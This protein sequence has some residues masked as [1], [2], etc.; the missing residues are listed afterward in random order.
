M[1]DIGYSELLLIAVVA[2]IVIGPKDL[3]RVMRTVGQWVGRARGMARHFRSGIDT[4][5]REAELEE[6]EKKWREENERILRDH[7][8]ANPLADPLALEA[9]AEVPADSAEAP[10]TAG[11]EPPVETPPGPSSESVDPS[12]GFAGPPHSDPD[13]VAHGEELG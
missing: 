6:M 3:P 10:P 4:M 7:P 12:T 1:F 8:F 2:L 9:P 13:G 11:A 5:M